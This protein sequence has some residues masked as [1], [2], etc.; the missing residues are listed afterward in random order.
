MNCLAI[1]C[2]RSVT[3][4]T[5]LHHVS[6]IRREPPKY[7]KGPHWALIMA[8]IQRRQD[9]GLSQSEV[10]HRVG[11]ATGYCGKLEAGMRRPGVDTLW[12]WMVALKCEIILLPT[13]SKK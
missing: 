1:R 9:I 6:H 8:L 5:T 7:D 12:D 2:D 11:W 4:K 13:R 10:D 3:E